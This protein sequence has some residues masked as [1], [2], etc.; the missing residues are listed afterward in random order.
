MSATK[1]KRAAPA[2][3]E[4]RFFPTAGIHAQIASVGASAEEA[5][6][7][8]TEPPIANKP[9]LPPAPNNANIDKGQGALQNK[10]L[11]DTMISVKPLV[12]IP[13]PYLVNELE[14]KITA[15]VNVRMPLAFK[16]TIIDHCYAT[17]INPSEWCRRAVALLLS[18]EQE[19]I[20]KINQEVL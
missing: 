17:K 1:T 16:N 15:V 4:S 12:K 10:G 9:I 7:N 13:E 14:E 6:I 11:Y 20:R 2:K 19:A 5:A 18:V 3:K 8:A